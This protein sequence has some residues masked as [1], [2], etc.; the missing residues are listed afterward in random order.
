M[1]KDELF[2]F[3]Q[4]YVVLDGTVNL[5]LSD[6]KAGYLVL[7]Y[8]TTMKEGRLDTVYEVGIIWEVPEYAEQKMIGLNTLRYLVGRVDVYKVRLIEE[9]PGIRFTDGLVSFSLYTNAELSHEAEDYATE[10]KISVTY[11][12]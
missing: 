2:D 3:M 5:E 9:H 4:K 6:I 11:R 12:I 8:Q 1:T 10:N 7:T